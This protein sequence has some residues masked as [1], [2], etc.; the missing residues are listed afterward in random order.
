MNFMNKEY[1][2]KLK[3]QTKRA[4]VDVTYEDFTKMRADPFLQARKKDVYLDEDEEEEDD[5]NILQDLMDYKNSQLGGPQ[6]ASKS[7]FKS[8]NVAGKAG[9]VNLK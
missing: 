8:K 7:A 4:E 3:D 5:N 6:F 2:A 9:R 1:L